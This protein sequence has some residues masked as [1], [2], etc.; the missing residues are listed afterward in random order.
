MRRMRWL[1]RKTPTLPPPA[2][3]PDG[4][5]DCAA[6]DERIRSWPAFSSERAEWLAAQ[7]NVEP[8]IAESLRRTREAGD[9]Y[10]FELYVVAAQTHPS[11]LYTE[12]LCQVLDERR[13][14]MDSEGIV[15]ALDHSRDPAAVPSLRRAVT[16][17]P[18]WD[19]FGQLARKAVW[20]L[21]AI[22]TPEALAA[23]REEITDDLPFKVVEAAAEALNRS[24]PEGDG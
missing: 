20:A 2:T 19:E 9:W 15:D 1:R 4:S 14:D 12:T 16:W 11:R 10:G 5:V 23:I 7:R 3:N 21:D 13:D 22:G 18:D 24:E 8:C 17:V 6:L